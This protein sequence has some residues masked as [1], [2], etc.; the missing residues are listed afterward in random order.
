MTPAN[1]PK[2][3]LSLTVLLVQKECQTLRYGSFTGTHFLCQPLTEPDLNFAE[4]LC[5]W[6][7]GIVISD[8]KKR[9]GGKRELHSGC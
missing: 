8:I 4:R 1:R 5:I 9:V 3:Q 6:Q 7:Q 2:V